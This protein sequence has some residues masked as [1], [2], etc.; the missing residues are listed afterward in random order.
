MQLRVELRPGN[1][2]IA[3]ASV[4]LFPAAPVY[5]EYGNAPAG[6]LR[7]PTSQ[8]A[9]THRLPIVRLRARSVYQVRAFALDAIGCPTAVAEAEFSSGELPEWLKATVVKSNGRPSYPLTLMDLD[10]TDDGGRRS[11]SLVAFDK[12]MQPVWH[13]EMPREVVLQSTGR[14]HGVMRL[15]NGNLLYLAPLYGV[16]EITS[17]TRLVRRLQLNR[18][19]LGPHHDA[20]ELPDGRVL[21]LSRERRVMD[22]TRY[23]GRPEQRVRGDTLHV[24]DLV[25]GAQEQVWSA[26]DMLNPPERPQEWRIAPALD[27]PDS[28]DVLNW[29]HANSVSV[30]SGGKVLISLRHLHSVISLSPDFKTVEWRLGSFRSS[31]AFPNPADRFYGQH[32]AYELA[33]RH[34]LLFD[35]GNF[36]P[37]GNYSRALELELDFKQMTSRKVW[38]Y[39]H[40]PDLYVPRCGNAIRL[41]NGNTLVNFGC[42]DDPNEQVVLA[43]AR[44]DGMAAWDVG[45]R[46]PGQRLSSYRAYPCTSLAGEAQAEPTTVPR[47]LDDCVPCS[48]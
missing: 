20:L 23:G 32:A 45:L 42:F 34:I 12:E 35:N 15:S 37:E 17:D 39:R 22:D 21:I 41:P 26:F 7:T 46:L 11:A 47:A 29:T 40:E 28:G 3:D 10:L 18:D 43:E 6:W 1:A 19:R 5:L 16:E 14:P 33:D 36:R 38:E 8:A 13:Y 30:T 9:T 27:E 24:L 4:E 31:F 48:C 44:P 2:L 25:T